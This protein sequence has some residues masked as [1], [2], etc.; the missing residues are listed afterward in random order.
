MSQVWFTKSCSKPRQGLLQKIVN[1]QEQQENKTKCTNKQQ[2]L[3][4]N[5]HCFLTLSLTLKQL[6]AN[7]MVTTSGFSPGHLGVRAPYALH[8]E[9]YTKFSDFDFLKF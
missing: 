5:L 7:S 2:D 6:D 4:Q 3:Q 1:L 9:P 8:Y